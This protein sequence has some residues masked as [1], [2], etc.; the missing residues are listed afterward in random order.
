LVS[1]WHVVGWS[2]VRRFLPRQPVSHALSIPNS[3]E[4]FFSFR[5]EMIFL[6]FMFLNQVFSYERPSPRTNLTH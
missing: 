2:D 4:L 3:Q 5:I 6:I 1:S